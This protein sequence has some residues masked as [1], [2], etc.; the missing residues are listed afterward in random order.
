M[1]MRPALILAQGADA[2]PQLYQYGAIGILAAILLLAAYRLF[3]KLE[4]T[5]QLERERVKRAEDALALQNEYIRD[6]VVPALERVT[7]VMAQTLETSRR[8]DHDERPR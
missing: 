8:G 7:A 6:R 1:L 4:E 5:L 3:K 2:V